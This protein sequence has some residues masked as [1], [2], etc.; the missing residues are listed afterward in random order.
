MKI[1]IADDEI[2]QINSITDR[3]D[4]LKKDEEYSSVEYFSSISFEGVKIHCQ[5]NVFDLALIDY[6]W[7]DNSTDGY[8]IAKYLKE[9]FPS[10]CV[11]IVSGNSKDFSTL[12]EK[13]INNMTRYINLYE[14]KPIHDVKDLEK[15]LKFASLYNEKKSLERKLSISKVVNEFLKIYGG[16]LSEMQKELL[17]LK[18]PIIFKSREFQSCVEKAEKASRSQASVLITGETGCGKDLL[19]NLIHEKSNRSK[20]PFVPVNCAA[21]PK[22]LVESTLFGHEK[23]SFTSAISKKIGDFERASGGTLFLDE[24]GDLSIDAQAKILRALQ[25]KKITRVGG[26][27]EIDVDIRIITATNKKLTDAIVND[28]FRKDLFYRLNTIP[29]SIPSLKNRGNDDIM[30]LV[31][32]FLFHFNEYYGKSSKFEKSA[33][34]VFKTTKFDFPGNVRELSNI[35]DRLVALSSGTISLGD[36]R[37]NAPELLGEVIESS[38]PLN[39]NTP[40]LQEQKINYFVNSGYDDLHYK[41]ISEDDK[42][43]MKKFLLEFLIEFVKFEKENGRYPKQYEIEPF[44]EPGNKKGWLSSRFSRSGEPKNCQTAKEVINE[45]PELELLKQIAPFKKLF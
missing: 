10:I 44:L 24:I 35:V 4:D 36:I 28:Q 34:D 3:L 2:R 13:E 9:N 16:D 6:V 19:A 25:E 38:V 30:L 17:S 39:G 45:Y 23:G 29:I 37:E 11:V 15:L 32:F 41:L 5:S 22:D 1:L 40:N 12:K 26:S 43:K 42:I 7:N 8:K 27:H 33:L 21:I 18:K 20:K 31:H 14:P